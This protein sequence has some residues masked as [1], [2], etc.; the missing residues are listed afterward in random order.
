MQLKDIKEDIK[1]GTKEDKEVPNV[2]GMTLTQI[3]TTLDG[4]TILTSNGATMIKL[5]KP[6][7]G[8]EDVHKA[9]FRS[10]RFNKIFLLLLIQIL[11]LIM[12]RCLKH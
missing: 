2:L 12:I 7:K 9:S 1:E 6:N 11:M 4:G 3:L 8:M 5:N 10:L